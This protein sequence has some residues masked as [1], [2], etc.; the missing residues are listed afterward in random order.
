MHPTL[1]FV[2][3]MAKR[4][5]QT[6][7]IMPSGAALSRT[8]AAA[9]GTLPPGSSVLELG[10]GTGVF[11]REL[12]RAF[13]GHPVLAVEDNPVFVRQLE[14]ST[15]GAQIIPGCASRLGELLAL[16]GNPQIGTVVSGIPLLSLDPALSQAI[17]AAVVKVLP[18][19]ARFVQFTYSQ[20]LW[21]RLAVPGLRPLRH[22]RVWRNLPPAVV[23][24][25]ERI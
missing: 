17:L 16:H 9:V 6:G 8:M 13:P 21:K 2:G 5:R 14:H 18:P 15:P 7:A 11:T 4:W 10:P 25:F 23:M 20:L 1:A 19:G 3:Q 12:L 24:P 22:R